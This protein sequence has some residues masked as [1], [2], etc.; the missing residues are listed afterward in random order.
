[1]HPA[2]KTT[3]AEMYFQFAPIHDPP[4]LFNGCNRKLRIVRFKDYYP[5]EKI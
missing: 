1:M 3:V 5:I 4:K 2:E